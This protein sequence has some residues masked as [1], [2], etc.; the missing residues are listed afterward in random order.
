MIK[1]GCQVGLFRPNFGNLALFQ[2]G[3]P[4]N[5]LAFFRPRLK[6]VGL[7]KFRWRFDFFGFFT[8]KVSSAEKYLLFHYFGNTFAKFL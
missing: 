5:F 8:L 1:K 2:V 4:K 6:L 3:S 7:K